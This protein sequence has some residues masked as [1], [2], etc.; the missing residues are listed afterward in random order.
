MTA[1]L[2][3]GALTGFGVFL[4]VAAVAPRRTDL[5]VAVGRYDAA[6]RAEA[7]PQPQPA[8][9]TWRWRLGAWTRRQAS[10]RGW[11]LSSNRADLAILDRSLEAHLAAKLV[12]AAV[13]LITPAVFGALLW[14]AGL[15]VS[16]PAPTVAAVLL[17]AVGFLVPDLQLRR[18]ARARRRE[19][20]YALAEYYNLVAINMAGGRAVSQ[21][22]ATVARRCG[23]WAFQ[24]LGDAVA[25]AQ[26]ASTTPWHTLG[27]LGR[28]IGVTELEEFAGALTLVAAD[29]A[30]V[31]E[32]LAARAE[33]VLAKR[34]SDDEGH[35][36][37][38]QSVMVAVNFLFVGALILA[39][40]FPA[41]W[42]VL[43][44]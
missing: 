17:A 22:L 39:L 4:L 21:S 33:S 1:M 5:A 14:V 12:S 34:I 11:D 23:H 20:L 2:F 25:R 27:E 32:S 43:Q 36:G 8:G 16:W 7:T 35:A 41:S 3:F 29:G 18:D 26:H 40:L 13:G 38:K 28:R 30:K 15:S 42:A 9:A 37:E 24:T 44:I 19:F 6:R 31:K 10:T